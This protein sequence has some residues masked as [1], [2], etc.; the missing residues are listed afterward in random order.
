RQTGRAAAD[1]LAPLFDDAAEW[2]AA[3]F[4]R[5]LADL[6]ARRGWGTLEHEDP[7]PGVGA[8]D[9]PD[10][11]EADPSAGAHRPSCFFTTGLL[12]SLLGR[13]A[14]DDA[15]IG[16]LEV[17]CRSRGDL[18]CRFLFGAHAALERVHHAVAAGR[19]AATA[20]AELA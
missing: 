13:I 7:H 19:D 3:E 15:D 10:W 20:L 12:A 6:L 4:W 9:S 14:G 5:R 18:R 1:A 8:L 17:E 11:S 2:P 16:V